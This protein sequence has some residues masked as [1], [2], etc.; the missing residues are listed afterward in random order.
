MDV[1]VGIGGMD[2]ERTSTGATVSIGVNF[3]TN[4]NIRKRNEGATCTADGFVLSPAMSLENIDA[5]QTDNYNFQ[6][7]NLAIGP[8]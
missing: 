8:F 4:G 1:R 5:D 3:V 7:D 6:L 2:V